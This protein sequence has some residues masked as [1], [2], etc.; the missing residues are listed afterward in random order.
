MKLAIVSD[1]HIEFRNVHEFY[2]LI[3]KINGCG[4]DHVLHAGDLSPGAIMRDFFLSGME[5]PWTYVAGNHDYYGHPLDDS[6]GTVTLKGGLRLTYATLWTDFKKNDPLVM[7]AFPSYMND[8][9]LIKKRAGDPQSIATQLYNQHVR[10]FQYIKDKQPDIVMTHHAPSFQSMVEAF[11]HEFP[12][13]YYYFSDYDQFI[14]DNP[15]IKLWVHGHT[16]AKKDYMIG[17][18]RI[19]CNPL[20]YPSEQ[21]VQD[22]TPLIVEV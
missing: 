2:Q 12:S 15:K 9:K 4:A 6:H 10:H 20:G 17:S 18:T 5:I 21:K 13:N 7:N 8:A 1:L 22:Y 16:H 19:V 11:K 3:E 14:E